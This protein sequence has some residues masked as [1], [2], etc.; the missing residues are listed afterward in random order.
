MPPEVAGQHHG[1]QSCRRRQPCINGVLAAGIVGSVLIAVGPVQQRASGTDQTSNSRSLTG[2]DVSWSD[3]DFQ[4][5]LV[6]LEKAAKEETIVCLMPNEA[7]MLSATASRLGQHARN[8]GPVIDPREL[9][10]PEPR[11][12]TGHALTFSVDEIAA[13]LKRVNET[14]TILLQSPS[15]IRRTQTGTERGDSSMQ[16]LSP[17]TTN[18]LP[19]PNPSS[20]SALMSTITT[21][22]AGSDMETIKQLSESL[23]QINTNAT[24]LV[25]QL[26]DH[27]HDLQKEAIQQGAKAAAASSG[28]PKPVK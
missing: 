23:R 20:L 19:D 7:R 6:R 14:I 21:T 26:D 15:E 16:P 10:D 13:H 25:K 9:M 28:G 24:E 11:N 5:L 4:A 12:A 3:S 1:M 2:L 22:S 18:T 8:P 17:G 27:A